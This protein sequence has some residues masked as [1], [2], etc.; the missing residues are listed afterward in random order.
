MWKSVNL[1]FG[2]L[3]LF[4]THCAAPQADIEPSYSGPVST[5]KPFELS[6]AACYTTVIPES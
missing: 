1:N 4:L 2:Q 6:S 3:L 5:L